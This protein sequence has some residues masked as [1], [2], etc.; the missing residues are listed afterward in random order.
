MGRPKGTDTTSIPVGV[1]Q[2]IFVVTVMQTMEQTIYIPRLQTFLQLST[3]TFIPS[4]A[5]IVITVH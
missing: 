5:F 2:E 3:P 4:L 1:S